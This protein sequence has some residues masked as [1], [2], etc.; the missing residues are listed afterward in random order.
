MLAFCWL[1]LFARL[2]VLNRIAISPAHCDHQTHIVKFHF[3]AIMERAMEMFFL[4]D[5]YETRNLWTK[6]AACKYG[7]VAH[8]FF[9]HSVARMFLSYHAQNDKKRKKKFAIERKKK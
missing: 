7:R 9:S 1:L 5:F 3:G 6:N 2:Y 4:Y 8:T